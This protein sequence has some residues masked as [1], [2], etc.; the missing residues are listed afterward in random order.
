M[1]QKDGAPQMTRSGFIIRL[2]LA[3]GIDLIDF[4]VG[5]GFFLVPWEESIG[6]LA[7]LPLWGWSG[8]LYLLELGDLTEQV[9]AFIPTASLIGLVYGWRK[10]VFGKRPLK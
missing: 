2:I 5:R 7:L 4:T 9:D 6:A 10:G 3:A 8:L 1:A